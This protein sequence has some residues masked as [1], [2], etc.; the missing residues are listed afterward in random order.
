MGG[1]AVLVKKATRAKGKTMLGVRCGR[2]SMFAGEQSMCIAQL[3]GI[4]P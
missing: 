1:T 2:V 4:P 3:L